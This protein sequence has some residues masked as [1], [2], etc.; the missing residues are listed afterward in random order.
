MTNVVTNGDLIVTF[1]A[2]TSHIV[3]S[4]L[5][6]IPALVLI[7]AFIILILRSILRKNKSKPN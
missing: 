3:I 7:V 5:I 2:A 1:T 6:W 4:P